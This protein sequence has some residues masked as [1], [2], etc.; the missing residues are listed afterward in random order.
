MYNTYKY[1]SL[2]NHR[3]STWGFIFPTVSWQCSMCGSPA[4][5][6]AVLSQKLGCVLKN[7]WGQDYLLALLDCWDFDSWAGSENTPKGHSGF[8]LPFKFQEEVSASVVCPV[9]R[10]HIALG[11]CCPAVSDG[12]G[13][14][15][16]LLCCCA[17][18]TLPWAPNTSSCCCFCHLSQSNW[19]TFS[20]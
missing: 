1:K 17:P 5:D 16:F 13:N 6:L 8:L 2:K 10:Y 9:G 14:F 3:S 4:V 19:K 12:L 11:H 20:I 18:L 7:S 15:S